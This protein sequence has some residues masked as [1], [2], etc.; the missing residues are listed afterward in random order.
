MTIRE[1]FL[2][3]IQFEVSDEIVDMAMIDA[4]ITGS[5]MYTKADRSVLEIAA[6][7]VLMRLLIIKEE[8]EGQLTIT[9]DIEGIKAYALYLAKKNGLDEIVDELSGT[10]KISSVTMW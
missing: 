6:I 10:P 4:D 5:E 8:R 1:A 2:G 9:R 3:V 7:D